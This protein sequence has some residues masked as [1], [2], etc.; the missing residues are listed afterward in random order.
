MQAG[1]TQD[2]ASSDTSDKVSN[3]VTVKD[4]NNGDNRTEKESKEQREKRSLSSQMHQ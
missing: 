1:K 4:V 3:G 2:T